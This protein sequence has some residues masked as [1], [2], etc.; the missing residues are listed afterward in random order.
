M[1]SFFIS[2]FMLF[3]LQYPHVYLEQFLLLSQFVQKLGFWYIDI[4]NSTILEAQMGTLMAPKCR[5]RSG[6]EGG[7][8]GGGEFLI[9]QSE[10]L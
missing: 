4:N 7:G 6:G 5:Y 3:F 2:A 9:I 8:G 10:A 1:P